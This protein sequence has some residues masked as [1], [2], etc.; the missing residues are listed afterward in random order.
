M[1]PGQGGN[2]GAESDGR[3]VRRSDWR[4][5]LSVGAVIPEPAVP[6]PAPARS[7]S[8][9]EELA[10]SRAE[11]AQERRDNWPTRPYAEEALS[12]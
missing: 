6:E 4:A 2:S 9:P 7:A 12:G 8:L 5:E 3:L 11:V 1:L 10:G